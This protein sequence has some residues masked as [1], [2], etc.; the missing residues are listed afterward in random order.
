MNKVA[1]EQPDAASSLRTELGERPGY[2]IRRLHQIHVALFLE[3]CGDELTPVQYG[4]MSVLFAQPGMDQISLAAEV[5]IDRTNV[6]DVLARLE[7]RGMLR[8][9][10]CDRDKRMKRAHL[11]PA[12]EGLVRRLEARMLA[13]QDRLMAPLPPDRRRAFLALLTELVDANNAYSRAP[14]RSG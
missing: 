5:G 10:V 13:A 11:T 4:V 9:A 6:A 7:A 2:L 12:G 1:T 14:A 8:R 3:E